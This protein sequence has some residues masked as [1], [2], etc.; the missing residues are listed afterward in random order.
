ML[1]EVV[2]GCVAMVLLPVSVR[3][4]TPSERSLPSG[5][6]AQSPRDE[7]RPSIGYEPKG[8]AK[9]QGAFLLTA[10]SGVGQHGWVQK[11]FSV[12]GGKTY[13]FH[14]L[15]QTKEI[16]FPRRST[17]A[18]VVWQDDRGRLV[19][20][21]FA[22]N[23]QR[24]GRPV[25]T[26]E[27]E[28]PLDAGTNKDGWTTVMGNYRAPLAATKAVVELHLQWAPNGQV[29]WSEPTFEQVP[30]EAPRKVRLATIHYRPSGK[31]PLGNCEEFGPVITEAVKQGANLVVLGETV[32]YV[33][34]GKKP[35]EIAEPI[36]GPCTEYFCNLAKKLGVYLVVSLYER[37]GRVVYNVALLIGPD[38][39]VVG[40]YRK[41]CL[42][43]AEVE[44]GVMPGSEYPVF[45]T[46]LGKIGMMVCYDGFFP[47]V[48]RELTKNGAE[49]IAWPVWGCDPLLA[50]ARANENRIFLV[51]STYSEPERQW[52]LS[53]VY[54][55]DGTPISVAKKWGDIAMAE[56]D[57]S[58]RRVGPYNLGDFNAMMHRHRPVPV[59]EPSLK[60]RSK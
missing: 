13:R 56:V 21:E 20:A 38:G 30:A 37:D 42:P 45:E 53:A 12:E 1:R 54:D 7:I 24:E 5:W 28:H 26:A 57:L 35:H 27:P 51:S 43:H 36:P 25:P 9:G 6:T 31:S 22:A 16:E 40:K 60:N 34:V 46:K 11:S 52:M 15:R 59:P 50:K 10:D 39:R 47:E 55:R 29:R 48:A 49:I 14:A 33:S 18:R 32:H 44:A 41:V 3:A 19:R 4:Q 2:Y 23:Q 58:D 17:L 8:G